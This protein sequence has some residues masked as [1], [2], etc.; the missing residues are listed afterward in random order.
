MNY[1]LNALIKINSTPNP[2]IISHLKELVDLTN[3]YLITNEFS[4]HL[5][6]EFINTINS[7][8]NSKYIESDI[9]VELIK[10]GISIAKK[11]ENKNYYIQFLKDAV[12]Y[13]NHYPL[14]FNKT[15]LETELNQLLK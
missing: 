4:E 13:S 11:A 15:E 8:R 10:C 9:D 1:Y 14:L 7:L 12:Y 6:I 3:Q 2:D 5:T